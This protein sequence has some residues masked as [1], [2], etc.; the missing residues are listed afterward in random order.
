MAAKSTKIDFEKSLAQ[1]EQLVEKLEGSEYT[2]EQ[3][4]SAFEKGI[5]LTRE[6]QAALQDAEQKVQMLI[7]QNGESAAVPFDEHDSDF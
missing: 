1:L 4:L 5:K 3:S 7:E 6:C 2:L